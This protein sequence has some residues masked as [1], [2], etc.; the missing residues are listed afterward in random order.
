MAIEYKMSGLRFAAFANERQFRLHRCDKNG[1]WV[2]SLMQLCKMFLV[3]RYIV[4]T[5]GVVVKRR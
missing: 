5:A 3:S 1:R 4:E 2:L